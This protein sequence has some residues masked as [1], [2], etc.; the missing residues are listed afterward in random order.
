MAYHTDWASWPGMTQ[1]DRESMRK[2][3]EAVWIS[4]ENSTSGAGG[5]VPSKSDSCPKCSKDTHSSGGCPQRTGPK[6]GSPEKSPCA[7]LEQRLYLRTGVG[8]ARSPSGGHSKEV[9]HP[10][11]VW[12]PACRWS[13]TDPQPCWDPQGL[14]DQRCCCSDLDRHPLCAEFSS[15]CQFSP[16]LPS[17]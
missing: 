16:L 13:L 7:T 4:R 14:G 2:Q 11:K 8:K 12:Q 5:G 10:S 1:E 17:F 3:G 15:L 9:P 6:P